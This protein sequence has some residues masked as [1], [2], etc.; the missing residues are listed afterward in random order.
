[1]LAARGL[2]VRNP[3]L[4]FAMPVNPTLLPGWDCERVNDQRQTPP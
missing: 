2:A 1:M 3:E 4:T